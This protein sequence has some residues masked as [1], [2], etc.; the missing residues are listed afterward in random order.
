MTAHL[1][2]VQGEERFELTAM[3]DVVFLL[4]IFFLCIDFRVLEAKLPASLPDVGQATTGMPPPQDV[5]RLRVVCDEPGTRVSMGTAN[6][7]VSRFR[8]EGHR[9]SWR[10]GPVAFRTVADL[11]AALCDVFNDPTRRSR[12]DDGRWAAL[13]VVIQPGPATTYGDVARTLDAVKA[14]GFRDVRFG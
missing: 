2:R 7:A 12:G 4:I 9:V 1:E 3:I 11:R 14:C 5:L 10:L 6:G 8:L 13:P